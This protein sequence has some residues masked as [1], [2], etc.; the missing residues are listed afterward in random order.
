[1]V[2]IIF[3]YKDM[4]HNNQNNN[5][6]WLFTNHNILQKDLIIWGYLTEIYQLQLKLHII[7]KTKKRTSSLDPTS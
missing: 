5:L 7:K 3:I 2:W 6:I 4:T 1:M